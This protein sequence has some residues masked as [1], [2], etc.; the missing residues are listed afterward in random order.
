MNFHQNI[1]QIL[2]AA[3]S[4]QKI[5]WN[6]IFLKFGDRCAISQYY[7]AGGLAGQLNTYAARRMY[8]AYEL[9]LFGNF[10]PQVAAVSAIFYDENNAVQGQAGNLS[11]YWDVTAAGVRYIANNFAVNNVYFSCVTGLNWI[12]FKGFTLNY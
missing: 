3:T 10:T 9:Q 7:F 8:V 11:T 4:E 5:L 2:A 1:E 12:I 6:D